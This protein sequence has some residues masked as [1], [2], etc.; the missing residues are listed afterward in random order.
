MPW[1]CV[2]GLTNCPKQEI[3]TLRGK[4]MIWLISGAEGQCIP[5]VLLKLIEK[6]IIQNLKHYFSFQAIW[7]SWFISTL[8]L[9]SYWA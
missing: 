7:K 2:I 6:T 9:D 4:L 3:K 5:S 1:N 8:P